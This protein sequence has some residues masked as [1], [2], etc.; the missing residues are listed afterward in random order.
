MEREWDDMYASR[1]GFWRIYVMAVIYRY[2]DCG[3][4]HMGF[5]RVRCEE[6]GHE[7]LPAFFNVPQPFPRRRQIC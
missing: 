6:C 7:Y 5:A 2:L 4:L 3:E 1:Y